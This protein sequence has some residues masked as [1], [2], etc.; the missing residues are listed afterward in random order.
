[1]IEK[2][3]Q[4]IG[5]S[6]KEIKVYVTALQCGPRSA[7]AI[8][9]RANINRVTC[10]VVLEK[11]MKFGLVSQVEG[12]KGRIFAAESP[13][14][15]VHY[16]EQKE[17]EFQLHRA[18]IDKIMPDLM[19]LFNRVGDRPLVRYFEG[20]EGIREI[21][22]R[23]LN[24]NIQYGCE[25][26]SLDYVYRDINP[27]EFYDFKEELM[28]REFKG[29]SILTLEKMTLDFLPEDFV[30]LWDVR[31]LPHDKFTFPGDIAIFKD[32]AIIDC[33]EGKP[34]MILLEHPQ[35]IALLQGWFDLAWEGAEKFKIDLGI[36]KKTSAKK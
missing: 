3:M 17:K 20:M 1:M 36:R 25:I 2:E 26:A 8:A 31:R 35:V 5:F 13:E 30:K 28:K 23:I 11:L 29:R 32:F 15:L 16:I 33:Y 18:G 21:Q 4:K 6:P 7:Q 14:K 22:Q 27:W 9:R 24:S 12:E 19:A 34:V 10:Y